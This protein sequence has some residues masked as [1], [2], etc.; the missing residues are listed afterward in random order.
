[1]GEVLS[2]RHTPDD[3]RASAAGGPEIAQSSSGPE[4]VPLGGAVKKVV[5]RFKDGRIVKGMTSDF[6][7]QSDCFHVSERRTGS[8]PATVEVEMRDLKALFFV[9]DLTGDP[10]H[11]EKKEFEPL[12]LSLQ[13]GPR[14]RVVFDDGEVLVGTR[15]GYH[16]QGFF[17]VPVDRDSNIER[18]WVALGSVQ[19]TAFP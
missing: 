5:A 2:F 11:V 10:Q 3:R 15:D 9:K 17:L 13:A 18:C 16:P 4:A 8:G 6:V 19:E 1:M 14:M 12:P 7:P